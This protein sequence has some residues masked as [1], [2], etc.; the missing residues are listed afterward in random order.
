MDLDSAAEE[1]RRREEWEAAERTKMEELEEAGRWEEGFE[2]GGVEEEVEELAGGVGVDQYKWEEK[3]EAIGRE[4]WRQRNQREPVGVRQ[5]A[6][7]RGRGGGR[8]GRRGRG[9]FQF[10]RSWC[11]AV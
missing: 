4:G 3:G 2:R 9:G 11:G 5:R 1:E 7:W 10:H 8:G 6:A